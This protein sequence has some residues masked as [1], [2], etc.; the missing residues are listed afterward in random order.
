MRFETLGA[1]GGTGIGGVKPAE[2]RSRRGK[3]GSGG[4]CGG[5]VPAALAF[6]ANTSPLR[7]LGGEALR[8]LRVGVA[9]S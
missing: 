7:A 9:P 1:G 6:R 8:V 3:C 2:W 5:P 4:A